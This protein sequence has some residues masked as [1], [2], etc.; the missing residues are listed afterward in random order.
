MVRTI[1]K[2]NPIPYYVQLADLL[3]LEIGE[4]KGYDGLSPLPSENQLLKRFNVSRSTVRNA[5]G[6]LEREGLI[7]RQK[8]KGSFIA[9]RRVEHELTQLVSTTEDMRRRGWDL[10]TRVI[11]IK[12]LTPVSKIAEALELALGGS[13]YGLQATLLH[14]LKNEAKRK[15]PVWQMIAAAPLELE[16]KAAAWAERW[17]KLGLGASVV[18]TQS[19]VG[20][21]SLPGETLPTRA[22]ALD[23]LSPDAFA[24]R[25]RQNDPPIVARIEGQRILVDPRTILPQDEELLLAGVE[26][27]LRSGR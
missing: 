19:T 6:L 3:R 14:Y 27:T 25:L 22:V 18:D 4:R 26:R 7:Y 10:T 2:S 15:I 12:R 13:V 16:A 1:D 11:G 9:V 21:G 24:E 17:K 23:L 20:G 8:G 5:L